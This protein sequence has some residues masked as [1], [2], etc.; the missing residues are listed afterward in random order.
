MLQQEPCQRRITAENRELQR[1]RIPV[2][3]AHRVR[4][5]E[6]HHQHRRAVSSLG[7]EIGEQ[8]KLQPR[9][10]AGQIGAPCANPS[11]RSL[12]GLGTG[13]DEPLVLGK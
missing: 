4:P 3:T 2:A 7:D 10:C 12:I 9:E 11:G 5:A 8:A 1:G 6:H 13:C